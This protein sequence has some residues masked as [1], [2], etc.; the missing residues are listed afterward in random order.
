[1]EMDIQNMRIIRHMFPIGCFPFKAS[2]Y[3]TFTSL[4]LY[5]ISLLMLSFG[6]A[7]SIAAMATFPMS[8]VI[9]HHVDQALPPLV[10]QGEP[11]KDNQVWYNEHVNQGS[12]SSRFNTQGDVLALTSKGNPIELW[13]ISERKLTAIFSGSREGQSAFVD[14]SPNGNLIA[15]AMS[16]RVELRDLRTRNLLFSVPVMD[17][18]LSTLSKNG[19]YLAS[20]IDNKRIDLW[21][22]SIKQRI[23]SFTENQHTISALAFSYDGRYLVSANRHG[24][25]KVWDV[26]EKR[27]M[28]D[29][30]D[31]QNQ[32]AIT[33]LVFSRD[34][35]RFVTVDSSGKTQVWGIERA[36]LLHTL[37]PSIGNKDD[38]TTAVAFSPNGQR[39]LRVVNSVQN[40]V[41]KVQADMFDALQGKHLFSLEP[42]ST[43]VSSLAFLP[44]NRSIAFSFTNKVVKLFDSASQH[45]VDTFGGQLLKAQ[46]A[47]VSPDGSVIVA[48]TVDGVLQLWDAKKKILKYSL[49][50]H[51]ESIEQVAFSPDARFILAGDHHG[52]ITLWNRKSNKVMWSIDAH[53]KGHT[54]FAMSP[55]NTALLTSS[56]ES[57]IMT[58]W[59]MQS[60]RP[61]YKFRGHHAGITGIC[62]TPDGARIVSSSNDGSV[63]VWDAA[64]RRVIHTF[65][66]DSRNK[67][68][69]ALDI[70]SDGKY[71]AAGVNASGREVHGIEIWALDTF[72]QHYSLNDH[73]KKV[74]AIKFSSDSKQLVSGSEDGSIKIWN[75]ETGELSASLHK[76]EVI[77]KE[78]VPVTSVAFS[79]NGREI[80]SVDGEGG[81]NSW[82]IRKRR[83]DY[84]MIGGPRGTWISE[85]HVKKRFWRGDDG[86]LIAKKNKGITPRSISPSGLAAKDMLVITT[87]REEL[88]VPEAGGMVR[89]TIKNRGRNPSFWLQVRQRDKK[90]TPVTLLP[91]K[92]TR[93]AAGQ[94]GVMDVQFIT[95]DLDFIKKTNRVK[96]HL[97]LVTKAGSK[98]PLDVAIKLV[99]KQHLDL[100]QEGRNKQK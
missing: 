34:S 72:E 81:V 54:L 26:M 2:Y 21:D 33:S 8:P 78:P 93:L 77:G 62:Y 44:D 19:R 7:P 23:H 9:R 36:E 53:K 1:M 17:G 29:L 38:F 41:Q 80:I 87:S 59:D 10:K 43:P 75:L 12:Y 58:L 27:F 49:T 66:S 20:A 99:K 86:S 55:D 88:E 97:E 94:T 70:S 45:F 95:H 82:N 56:T 14:I 50:G 52:N 18:A 24:L 89:I 92:L 22:T 74:T 30:N 73:F 31:D 13:N 48:G 79:K 3:R 4:F 16:G 46:Q 28:Y 47:A 64:T 83:L 37:T 96:L 68:F 5:F 91:N 100:E 25:I 67:K 90:N 69:T 60:H 40:K 39:I 57:S 32:A 42:L 98:F 76:K 63:K 71:L 35:K 6:G 15:F 61:I 84:T 65:V 85:N 51:N 11:V